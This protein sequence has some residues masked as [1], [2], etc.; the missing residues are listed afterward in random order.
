MVHVG[1]PPPLLDEVFDILTPGDIV[2]HCFN[3]KTAGSIRDTPALLAQAQ[4]AGRRRRA[5]GHRPRRRPRSDFDVA[6]RA[7]A[8]GLRPFSIS[9]DLH[10]RNIRGPVHDMATTLSK[11]LAVGLPFDE[12]IAAVTARPRGVLGLGGR[13][14]LAPG[15]KADFTV[16]DLVE[17]D[18]G[19]GRT[20]RAGDL[21][22]GQHLRAAD[23]RDRRGGAAGGAAGRRE[24][25]ADPRRSRRCASAFRGAARRA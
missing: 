17:R 5:H 8:E 2:T 12:C 10:L 15:A 3:G 13:D 24:R 7:I 25:G 16:F 14:G 4:A 11:L 23:D 22:L 18:A 21:T 9:T 6:R 19:R 1:E 20:A